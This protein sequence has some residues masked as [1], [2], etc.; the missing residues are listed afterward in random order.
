MRI[1]QEF[2]QIIIYIC[3]FLLPAVLLAGLLRI[4]QVYRLAQRDRPMRTSLV[5]GTALL[6]FGLYY[7]ALTWL[8][9]DAIFSIA[10]FYFDSTFGLTPGITPA[11][12]E[13]SKW[14]IITELWLRALFPIAGGQRCFNGT[15]TICQLADIA[16]K[17]GSPGSYSLI[18]LAMALFSTLVTLLLGIRF[19]RQPQKLQG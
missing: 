17:I 10:S 4:P 16:S 5:L 1:V 3:L 14:A 9:A 8:V 12:V 7:L 11:Q 15:A 13:Q 2:L 6:C 18:A 19:T